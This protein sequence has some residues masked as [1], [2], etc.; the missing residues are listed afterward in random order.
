M[1]LGRVDGKR[2]FDEVGSGIGDKR[3]DGKVKWRLEG[4]VDVRD[5]IE[6]GLGQLFLLNALD[7]SL[8]PSHPS[9]PWASTSTTL[10]SRSKVLIRLSFPRPSLISPF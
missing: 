1:G 5:L 6:I 7:W 10:S 8:R 4:A 9:P 3:R 2:A